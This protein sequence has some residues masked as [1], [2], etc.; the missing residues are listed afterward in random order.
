MNNDETGRGDDVV[1]NNENGAR[2]ASYDNHTAL[3]NVTNTA[4]RVG[5]V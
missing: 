5:R 3:P 1:D 4:E 2:H